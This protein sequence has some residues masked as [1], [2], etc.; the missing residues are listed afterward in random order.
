M[1]SFLFC[2]V[3]GWKRGICIFIW[4]LGIAD[5]LA[6]A[7][8][9]TT[10]TD[11]A[12]AENATAAAATAVVDAEG[13]LTIHLF[14]DAKV[15]TFTQKE[16]TDGPATAIDNTVVAPQVEKIVRDGQ[17]LIIRDGKT[18]NMMGQEVK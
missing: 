4:V 13:N 8:E 6:N 3:D 1:D 7:V 11:L 2:K 9:I 12:T 17:V 18:Y 14:A 15:Y 5:G 10:N 16:Q